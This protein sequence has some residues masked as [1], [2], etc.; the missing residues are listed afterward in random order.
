MKIITVNEFTI[1]FDDED[2]EDV[3]KQ[4]VSV[5]KFTNRVYAINRKGNRIH[6]SILGLTDPKIVVDH[7]NGDT[8]DNRRENLRT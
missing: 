4:G 7:I 2:Y 1:K 8:L 6:R 3:I 5:W